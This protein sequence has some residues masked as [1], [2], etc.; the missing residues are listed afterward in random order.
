MY[1]FTHLNVQTNKWNEEWI[2]SVLDTFLFALHLNHACMLYSFA[3]TCSKS[4]EWVALSVDQ[5]TPHNEKENQSNGGE[6]GRR[7]G[8]AGTHGRELQRWTQSSHRYNAQTTEQSPHRRHKRERERAEREHSHNIQ[9]VE[10]TQLPVLSTITSFIHVL[11]LWVEKTAGRQ[12]RGAGF[13][14]FGGPVVRWWAGGCCC[15]GM[16]QVSGVSGL[17]GPSHGHP[18]HL[19][20]GPGQRLGLWGSTGPQSHQVTLEGLNGPKMKGRWLEEDYN[21]GKWWVKSRAFWSSEAP[22]ST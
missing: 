1:I 22:P 11:C 16:S 20:C 6:M 15:G 3:L 8:G 7:G 5:P 19:L 17:R 14:D 21:M 13:G 12:T 9:T 2:K 4:R 10:G 18:I